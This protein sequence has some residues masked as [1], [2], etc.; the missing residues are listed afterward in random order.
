MEIYITGSPKEIADLVYEIQ[1]RRDIDMQI[2]REMISKH[3]VKHAKR[4]GT[5]GMIM[6]KYIYTAIK[7]GK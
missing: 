4:I 2:N 1:N 7:V 6:T 3:I 5:G